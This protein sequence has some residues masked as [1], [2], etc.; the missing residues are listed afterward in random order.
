MRKAER[1]VSSVL[2]FVCFVLH[3]SGLLTRCYQYTLFLSVPLPVEMDQENA[4][5]NAVD[6]TSAVTLIANRRLHRGVTSAHV[7]YGKLDS[8]IR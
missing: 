5:L 6:Q 2:R 4:K 7:P 3:L 8:G 1:F